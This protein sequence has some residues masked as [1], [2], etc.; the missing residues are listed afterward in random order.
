M[1]PARESRC[2]NCRKVGHFCGVCKS[3]KSIE[4]ISK[5][6]DPE[7]ASLGEVTK[8]DDPWTSTVAMEAM[9]IQ[10]RAEV[11]FKLSTGADVTLISQSDYRRAG[12]PSLDAST[13]RL[14][15]A[16][17]NVLQ[18]LG[19]FNGWLSQGGAVVDEDSTSSVASEGHFW[20]GG[21]VRLWTLSN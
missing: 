17:D 6:P 8:N 9:G 5:H 16:N 11:F 10:C 20:I 3:T 4:A 2:F 7:V 18:A 12:S 13:K 14:V 1:C 15:G 21:R 19:K